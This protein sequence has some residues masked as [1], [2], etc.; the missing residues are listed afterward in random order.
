MNIKFKDGCLVIEPDAETDY[1]ELLAFGAMLQRKPPVTRLG[2]AD[3]LRLLAEKPSVTVDEA[4]VVL[5]VSKNQTN[6]CLAALV[7]CKLLVRKAES[8]M[9]SVGWGGRHYVY[10]LAPGIYPPSTVE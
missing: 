7:E 2:W 8:C 4:A 6:N 3:V 5:G 10:E 1:F 9:R